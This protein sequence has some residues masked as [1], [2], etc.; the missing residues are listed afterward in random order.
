MS[1]SRVSFIDK[2]KAMSS[3][4]F[5]F[6]SFEK[7][8]SSLREG[9]T[10]RNSYIVFELEEP[11]SKVV[12]ASIMLWNDNEGK[13]VA[14]QV[15]DFTQIKCNLDIIEKYE[16]Q[17]VFDMDKD[18]ELVGTGLYKGDLILDVSD[19]DDV[20]LTDVSFANWKA[21]KRKAERTEKM[22]ALVNRMEAFKG[23]DHQA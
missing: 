1:N 6:I 8:M 11:Y 19:S 13:K 21:G 4:K 20:W 7:K 22:Q 12:T 10:E 2:L 18:D 23:R 3:V 5:S 17:F 16:N 14:R 15:V 9:E